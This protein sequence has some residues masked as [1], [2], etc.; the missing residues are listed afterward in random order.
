MYIIKFNIIKTK[1][2]IINMIINMI[3][4]YVYNPK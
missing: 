4:I 1:T 3:L 2:L